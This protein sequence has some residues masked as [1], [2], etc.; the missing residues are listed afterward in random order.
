M[1]EKAIQ[2]SD[3][4]ITLPREVCAS[5]AIDWPG[6]ILWAEVY[7]F[8]RQGRAC[9]LSLGELAD[10]IHRSSRQVSTYIGELQRLGWLSIEGV[11]GRRRHLAAHLPDPRS[12]LLPTKPT[13][14]KPASTIEADRVADTKPTASQTRSPLPTNKKDRRKTEENEQ[15]NT[16]RARPKDVEEVR[17]YFAELNCDDPDV[18]WD[19]WTS[20][21][22]RR[23]GGPIK[24][25]RAAARTWARQPF[26]RDNRGPRA[27][28]QL[29][30]TAASAWAQS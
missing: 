11:D 9:W 24:D 27:E 29:D 30:P 12:Q 16:G 15:E 3:T 18:F 17:T 13:S 23:K 2:H 20:A 25:W 26:R 8:T 7:S 22:W 5:D 28:R 6:K 14:T 1:R 4:F 21:G 10:R 19:Y